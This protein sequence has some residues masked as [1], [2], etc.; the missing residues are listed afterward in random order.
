MDRPEVDKYSPQLE[1]QRHSQYLNL[2]E[3]VA[4]IGYW[5][6]D[7]INECVFWSDE[8]YKIHGVTRNI[9]TPNLTSAINFY[10]VDDRAILEK[11]IRHTMETKEPFEFEL[12]LITGDSKQKYVHSKGVAEIDDNGVLVSIFGTFQDTTAQNALQIKQ[13]NALDFQQLMRDN[14]PNPIFVKDEQL[15]IVHANKQ[16]LSLYPENVRDSIIGTTTLE[17][18]SEE[19]LREF[20]KMDREAFEKGYSRV[21]ESIQF[22]TGEYQILDTQKIRFYNAEGKVFIVGISQNVTQR[23]TLIEK[24]TDSNEQLERF[25]HICSHDLKE[26]M[27]TVKNFTEVLEM[28][29]E[30]VTVVDEKAQKYMNIITNAAKRGQ[31][32]VTDVLAYSKVAKDD[33]ALEAVDLLEVITDI[34]Q[35]LPEPAT[36][37]YD[38]PTPIV[39]ANQTQIYQLFQNI[40]SNSVKYQPVGQKPEV[41]ITWEKHGEFWQFCIADNGIGVEPRHHE[42]VF[43]VLRR[44]HRHEAFPGSG[45]GLSICKKIVERYSGAIWMESNLNQGSKIYFQLPRTEENT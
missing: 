36:L 18:Y 23:E 13:Q 21:T 38:T 25:A 11:S 24:L 40:I 4:G 17:L 31:Q 43:D 20:T 28:H 15:Q 34:K 35:D 5:S 30:K 32:L 39:K 22:P 12:R 2:I 42:K 29:L 41:T 16:F 37:I 7:P 10:H 9:Y 27:R 1:L 19:E 14:D 26:P 33:R 8:V 45:V 44:L 6:L 3:Q